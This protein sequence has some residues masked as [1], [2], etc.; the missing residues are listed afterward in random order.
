MNNSIFWRDFI[1]ELQNIINNPTNVKNTPEL[2]NLTIEVEKSFINK[3]KVLYKT[4]TPDKFGIVEKYFFI[5][6]EEKYQ[7]WKIIRVFFLDKTNKSQDN[8]DNIYYQSSVNI[9]KTWAEEDI[10]LDILAIMF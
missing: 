8:K 3:V 6:L 5:D 2:K 10:F 7:Y 4:D 1:K 9:V